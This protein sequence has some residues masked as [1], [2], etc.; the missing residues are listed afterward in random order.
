MK[1]KYV[2]CDMKW[3][4]K[5]PYTKLIIIKYPMCRMKIQKKYSRNP[6]RTIMLNITSAI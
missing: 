6:F 2:H 5:I 4:Q 1:K 3:Q